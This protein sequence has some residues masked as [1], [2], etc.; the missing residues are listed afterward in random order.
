MQ[1]LLIVENGAP[2]AALMRNDDADG[3]RIKDDPHGFR[4]RREALRLSQRRLAELAGTNHS[5]I[6]TLET[7]TP[8]GRKSAS[9]ELAAIDKALTEAEERQARGA[10]AGGTQS[11]AQ[12]SAPA[13]PHL[14]IRG[15]TA[16][17]AIEH[18]RSGEFAITDVVISYVRTPE[19]METSPGVFA[20][21]ARASL[22]F[23]MYRPGDTLI[24][25]PFGVAQAGSGVILT[26]TETRRIV[27]REFVEETDTDWILRRYGQDPGT[28]TF[29]KDELD[30][31]AVVQSIIPGR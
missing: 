12:I 29:S 19:H 26:S 30:Q 6:Q 7:S 21:R 14:T 23:P 3:K 1:D 17:Y 10:P 13:R 20:V 16:V 18:E 24:A 31:I 15:K 4:A 8:T 5:R 22:M 28:D 9:T 2:M 25:N 27:I 11:A